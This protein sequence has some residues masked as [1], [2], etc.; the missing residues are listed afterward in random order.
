MRRISAALLATV[1]LGA[2]AVA[3][4]KALMIAMKPPAQRALS[5][6]VVVVGKVTS[7]ERDTVE[8][9]PFPGSPQKI[10]HKVAVVKVETALAGAANVTHLKVAFIPRPPA[11]EPAPAPPNGAPQLIRRPIRPGM[12][13]PELKVGDEFL[14]F[15]NKPAA[16]GVYLIPNMSPPIDAKTDEGKKEV[17]TVKKV[18]AVVA[19]PA[20]ALKADTADARYHAAAT[21]VTKYR[22][23]PETG[24]EVDQVP[25]AADE[26]RLILAALA[27][28]DW[29][30]FDRDAPNGL[31]AFYSLGLTD[32]DGWTPPK[33]APAK[34]GQPPVNFNQVTH[35]AFAA[36]V[37]GPGK[38]YQ[39]KRIVPKAK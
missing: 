29:T 31:Q 12:M 19:D 20:T 10:S 17:E 28:G 11:V 2:A 4:A 13:A 27:G 15:L 23:Y 6:D 8:I 7:V 37:A 26:S 18:L 34:P 24:G 32:K 9:A 39:I 38:D 22:A 25:V 35:D 33:P 1:A 16:G 3:P 5:A 14:L 30:K 21:L 36:W